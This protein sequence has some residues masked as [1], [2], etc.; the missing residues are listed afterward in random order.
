MNLVWE[1]GT[2][3]ARNFGSILINTGQHLFEGIMN[4]GTVTVF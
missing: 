1:K 3:K 2:G 4:E